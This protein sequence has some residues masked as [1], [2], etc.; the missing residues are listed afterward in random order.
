MKKKKWGFSMLQKPFAFQFSFTPLSATKTDDMIKDMKE[1]VDYYT[2]N[3]HMIK[4]TNE[5]ALYGACAKIKDNGMKDY[6]MSKIM[7][8]FLDLC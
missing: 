2:K 3:S 5:I 8:T 6:I 4:E 7:D 1:C